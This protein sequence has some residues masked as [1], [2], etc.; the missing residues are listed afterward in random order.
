MDGKGCAHA[1]A[2]AADLLKFF[3]RNQRLS[4]SQAGSIVDAVANRPR[5]AAQV[6]VWGRG[7]ETSHGTAFDRTARG[8]RSR[9]TEEFGRP[10]TCRSPKALD[11]CI[12]HARLRGAS[13]P[14]QCRC[15]ARRR[16]AE[17]GRESWRADLPRSRAFSAQRVEGVVGRASRTAASHTGATVSLER[18]LALPAGE[19]AA[20]KGPMVRPSP[21]SARILRRSITS[22]H[23]ALHRMGV[24]GP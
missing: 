24:V 15:P 7:C 17:I 5:T 21:G 16:I 8:C 12:R 4:A 13:R 9:T 10:T 3:G 23:E 18:T 1:T 2:H 20:R 19:L 14:T 22:N 11:R 6:F